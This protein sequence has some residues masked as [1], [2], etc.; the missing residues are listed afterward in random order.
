MSLGIA[1]REHLR[2]TILTLLDGAPGRSSNLGIL[3]DAVRAYGIM[4]T[5]DQMQSELRWLEEQGLVA[6]EAL[7]GGVVVASATERGCEVAAGIVAQPG[8][9]RPPARR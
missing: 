9:A 1:W 7:G 2:G 3:T 6:T 8:V 4:A 5:R